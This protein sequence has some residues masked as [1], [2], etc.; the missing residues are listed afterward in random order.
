[1]A[2]LELLD[3]VSEARPDGEAGASGSVVDLGLD[4]LSGAPVLTHRY[5]ATADSKSYC[6]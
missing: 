5:A 2:R 4:E 3:I 1:M 6:V